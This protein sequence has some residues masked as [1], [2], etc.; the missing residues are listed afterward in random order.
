MECDTEYVYVP[1]LA[2]EENELRRGLEIF[3]EW[4]QWVLAE[5]QKLDPL[6]K[7]LGAVLL[8]PY[9]MFPCCVQLQG[10][11]VNYRETLKPALGPDNVT[12]HIMVRGGLA[13]PVQ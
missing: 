8:P 2:Q 9:G 5:R 12:N 11:W 3:T 13:S 7:A 10:S 4:S 6:E 1:A